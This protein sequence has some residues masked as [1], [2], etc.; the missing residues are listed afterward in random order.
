MKR[1]VVFIAITATLLSCA[2]DQKVIKSTEYG[3]SECIWALA[4]DFV[5]GNELTKTVITQE[6]TDAPKFAWKEGDVIGV[7]PMNNETVQSNYKISEISSDPREAMFDGGV[8]ALKEGEEYA[9]YYPLKEEVARSGDSLTFSFLGQAQVANN[10]LAHLGAYD[11][12]YASSVVPIEGIAN[13]KFKHLIS[14]V[15]LQLTVP[16]SDTYSRVVLKSDNAWFASKA[17]LNLS[18]GTATGSDYLKSYTLN[19]NDI[20]V[21]SGNVLTLWLA[22]LPT[23]VLKDNKLTVKLFS[24]T[25]NWTG[26]I[27]IPDEFRAGSAYSYSCAP[28]L[29]ETNYVELGLSVKWATCNLGATSPEE[30]G[31]YYQWAGLEDVTSTDIYLDYSNCPYH[32]GSD[33][34]TGWT[35]YIPSDKSSFWS[36]TGSPD[37]KTV[38]DPK[39]DVAH[40][41]LGGNWRMPTDSEWTELK[42][43]CTWTW[44]SDYNGTGIAGYIAISKKSGYTDKT[45][46]LPA[47]GLRDGSA[48]GN[49][50]YYGSYWS[51][52]LYTNYPSF[53]FGVRF[54]SDSVY[55]IYYDRC[56][57]LSVRPV[58]E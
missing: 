11:Y 29:L 50:G 33:N 31:G 58:L 8:W 16:T 47:A 13:F 51:S 41:T 3:G 54:D 14:L 44:T 15:R 23:A 1:L 18:D 25:D 12:M 30:Y 20:S 2:K 46:F 19:L 39:D 17:S 24:V 6:D 4:P 7:I 36:G 45:I 38:L 37:N 26:E 48:L 56:R 10:S 42:N 9:A 35:K 40:V 5:C 43:N 32:S 22:L 49:V 55:R 27:S 21:S 52:S 57:G 53:A 34:S 28:D